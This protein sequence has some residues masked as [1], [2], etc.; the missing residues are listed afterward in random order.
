MTEYRLIVINT[1][2]EDGTWNKLK[3]RWISEEQIES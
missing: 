3:D 2:K 1:A